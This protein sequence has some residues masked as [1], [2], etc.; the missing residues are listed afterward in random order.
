MPK[1]TLKIEG[2]H[3]GLNTNSDPRDINDN[4]FPESENVKITKLGQIKT[5]G[6]SSGSALGGT[7]NNTLN[8]INRGLFVM[9][10]DRRVS[11]PFTETNET[12]IFAYDTADDKIDIHDV[13]SD[14]W[15]NNAIDINTTYPVYY[16]ADGIARVSDGNLVNDG[17]WFGY[18]GT[19]FFQ[20]SSLTNMVQD[21]WIDTNQEVKT[22]TN[23]KC[24]IS[25]P[26]V[27]SGGVNSSDSEYTGS[28]ID[29]IGTNDVVNQNAINLRVGFQY[30]NSKSEVAS[31]YSGTSSSRA[32]NSTHHPLFDKNILVTGAASSF[33]L[34][35]SDSVTLNEEQNILF[36]I[37]LTQSD[38]DKFSNLTFTYTETSSSEDLQWEFSKEDIIPDCWNVLSLSLTNATA[39]D[40]N[41]VGLDSWSLE[42][43]GTSSFNYYFSGI[44]ISDNPSLEGY[45]EGLYNFHYSY[46]YD[47]SKQES[48]PLLLN[49]VTDNFGKVNIIGNPILFNFDIYCCPYTFTAIDTVNASS[50]KIEK[51]GHGLAIGTAIRFSGITNANWATGNEEN[52]NIYYVSSE[53]YATDEFKISSSYANAISGTSL[54]ITGSNDTSGVYY[55][56]YSF[57]KR[58]SGSRIYYKKNQDDSYY[59]IGELDIDNSTFDHQGFSWFPESTIPSYSFSDASDNTVPVLNTTILVKGVSPSSSNTIDTFKSLNGYDSNISTIECKYKT[60]VVHGRRTYVGNIKQDGIIHSDRMIKSRVNKFDT[61]PSGVGVV[62]VAIRDG[63][64]IVKLEAFA[65]RILQF[66]QKSLYII[67]VSENID[68]LE[69]VYR[70]KGC[71]ID[72]HV[73]KTDYGITWFN[74]FGVYLY[75]GKSVTNLLEKDGIR[76][77]SESDWESFITSNDLDMSEAHIGYIPKRRQILIKNSDGDVFLY[78]LVLRAWTKGISN[79]FIQGSSSGMTN[80]ALDENQ[81]LFYL[82]D[83]ASSNEDNEIDKMVW[84][85]A[86]KDSGDFLLRTKDIDFGQPGVRKKI[87]K[88]YITYK[89]SSGASTYVDIKYDVNGETSFDK[90][91]QD[92]TNFSSNVLSTPSTSDWT[93][94]ELKPSTSSQANNIYSFALKMQDDSGGFSV[95][96]QFAINDITIVYR[97]KNVR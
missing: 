6:K 42:V 85:N 45:S 4:Q 96:R 78:D 64:S 2:F 27:G 76:L 74:K 36:G 25:T 47:K 44:V 3:G 63:E 56:I 24:L 20:N 17:K 72:Y 23:G 10:S 62:D 46:L 77:I 69:D 40:S 80:F 49:D 21:G 94:I 5:L 52:E 58:I 66:K 18:K 60:A 90:T 19:T 38:Y 57:N 30:R 32:D 53:S 51:T 59:L 55:H 15:T 70:N 11:S 61:F 29:G 48:L 86:S 65:D 12:L 89:G 75:D 88:V 81:D 93:T 7:P 73:T 9:G 83:D 33:T 82:N 31:G 54:P 71:E 87:Y 41:G 50:D 67:N 95:P 8:L 1:Q 28:V 43:T 37:L 79:I 84:D 97:L 39:G 13:V 91:F 92:T 26:Y 22:P 14:A 16:S 34:T 68:F 35:N